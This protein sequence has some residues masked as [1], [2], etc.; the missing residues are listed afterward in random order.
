MRVLNEPLRRRARHR[1]RIRLLA[2]LV[3][4]GGVGAL[5]GAMSSSSPEMVAGAVI[6]VSVATLLVQVF[7]W[8]DGNDQDGGLPPS[9][10]A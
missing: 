1:W 4:G 9:T 2:A 5:V 8:V 3:V 6:G 10:A 7:T